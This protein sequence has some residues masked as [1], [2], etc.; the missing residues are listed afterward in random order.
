MGFGGV[1]TLRGHLALPHR[2]QG[3]SRVFR[4]VPQDP[5]AHIT[6][7]HLQGF[8]VVEGREGKGRAGRARARKG[9]AL[10]EHL[11]EL[12]EELALSELS[13]LPSRLDRQ[14]I[15]ITQPTWDWE[16]ELGQG[17]LLTLPWYP[18]GRCGHVGRALAEV[19]IENA[20]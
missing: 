6:R 2:A 8:I 16:S 11:L 17:G 10:I 5:F 1:S 18:R 13:S 20:C 12:G 9:G 15:L 19:P 4:G 7:L 3:A 14:V